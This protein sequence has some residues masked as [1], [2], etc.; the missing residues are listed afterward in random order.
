[1]TKNQMAA[2]RLSA[3]LGIM[4]LFVSGCDT[5]RDE[6]ITTADIQLITSS[7]L[8][9]DG[10]KQAVRAVTMTGKTEWRIEC[11]DGGKFV[12]DDA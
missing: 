8:H 9:N 5:E 2:L 6:P 3:L 7:C 1:M 10:M 12:H 4:A 11:N